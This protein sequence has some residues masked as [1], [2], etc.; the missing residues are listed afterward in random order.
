MKKDYYELL[1]LDKN[2][3]ENDIKKAFR[4]AAMKYH[5]DKMANESEQ[6]KK[7]AEEKFKELNEAYQV[8]S[9]PEKKQLY[10][11]YGHAAFE[12]GGFNQS[13]GFSGFDFSDIFGSGGFG[14]FDFEDL[15]GSGFSSS[16]S[17][18]R[19]KK[20]QDM[21]YTLELNLREIADGVEKEIKYRR[22]GKCNHCNGSG[23]KD[24]KMKKCST[25]SGQGYEEKV[26]RSIFG[27]MKSRVECSKCNGAG[28]IPEQK[29]SHCF[30]SGIQK[31]EVSKKVKIP[32]GIEDGQR[33][34]V[35][36]SGAYGGKG[37]E[38]GDLYIQIREKIDPLFKRDGVNVYCKIPISFKLATLG[39]E[40]EIPTLRGKTK[41]KISEGTQNAMK[42][43]IKDG[44][45][46]YSY[47]IGSQIVEISVE[48]PTNLNKEQKK[49]LEEFYETLD[50][51]NEKKTKSFWEEL[52]DFFN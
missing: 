23:A 26:Q 25:C 33:L 36:Q 15:F 44:G 40:L 28:E 7:E 52:K 39:G 31:E 34:V 22:D 6:T 35:R 16:S 37:S 47:G 2:A 20:G 27:M 12:N 19:R 48:V 46:K 32:A 5:P 21:L 30:G 17:Q 50:E 29:C 4:K 13:S 3:S 43:K 38:Y 11:Q 24:S 14:G 41:I 51:K 18:K 9:D 45:I 1:G 49:K 8:L 42:Y 10:D